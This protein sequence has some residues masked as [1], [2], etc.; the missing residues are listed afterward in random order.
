MDSIY[1]YI[2][3]YGNHWYGNDNTV[4]EIGFNLKRLGQFAMA[5]KEVE[6]RGYMIELLPEVYMY[7]I[8]YHVFPQ[9]SSP[10]YLFTVRKFDK[11]D[12]NSVH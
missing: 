10:R 11:V 6:E 8:I 5:N 3:V 12:Y 7:Y 4:S 2:A 9:N 1:K